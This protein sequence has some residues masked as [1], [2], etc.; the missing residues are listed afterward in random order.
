[1]DPDASHL[2]FEKQLKLKCKSGFFLW[3][4]SFHSPEFH[5]VE[6]SRGLTP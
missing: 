3:T 1:M 5:E 6:N 4:S 2:G